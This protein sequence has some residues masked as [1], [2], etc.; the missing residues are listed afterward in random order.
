[1]PIRW[2]LAAFICAEA[3]AFLTSPH[4]H[5]TQSCKLYEAKSCAQ[6]RATAV[7]ALFAGRWRCCAPNPEEGKRRGRRAGLKQLL[8]L[9]A[10]SAALLGIEANAHAANLPVGESEADAVG[11]KVRKAAS[12]IPGLG[13]PDVVYPDDM[14]GR[15]RVQR[16]LADVEF[17][18]GEAQADAGIAEEM[19]AR[20][21]RTENFEA[22]FISGKGG[23]VADREFNTRSAI[24]A[25]EGADVTVQWKATN[26]NVLTVAYPNGVLRETKVRRGF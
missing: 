5:L 17:P 3:G 13:P 19:Q 2:L 12:K 18:K 25:T 22:R 4:G 15:W 26:P 23:T 16:V 8:Q 11:E 6:D 7:H 20:K 24:R 10:S 1:M 14:L 9:S 21:G